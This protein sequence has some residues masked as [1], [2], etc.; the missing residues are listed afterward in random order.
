MIPT[1]IVHGRYDLIC[2]PATAQALADR[3]KN[4]QITFPVAGHASSE[5][6]N[7]KALHD[8]VFAVEFG[9]GREAPDLRL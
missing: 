6:A 4:V 9:P 1:T 3:L 8:G 5:S 2:L 7:T